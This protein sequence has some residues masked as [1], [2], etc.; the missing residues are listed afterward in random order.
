MTRHSAVLYACLFLTISLRDDLTVSATEE[1]LQ[2]LA[3]QS[4]TTTDDCFGGKA[5]LGSEGNKRCCAFTESNFNA[6]NGMYKGCNSCGDET[7]YDIY[8]IRTPGICETC[9]SGYTYLDGQA[10]ST[11]SFE[12]GDY[13]FLGRCI[14][15]DK[16]D[17][18]T[19]YI[20]SM[21]TNEVHCTNKVAAGQSNSYSWKCLSG[22]SLGGFC[23]AEGVTSEGCASGM[24]DSGTGAC[25][26]KSSPGQ[27][28]TTTDDCFGGNAC[29]GSEGNKRCCT[30]TR[31]RWY[32]RTDRTTAR[33]NRPD[34]LE[35]S[36]KI[37]KILIA[38]DNDSR[39]SLFFSQPKFRV[40]PKAFKP[41]NPL[42]T[43][44]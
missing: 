44:F 4:C 38:R 2:S 21:G 27:S 16:C 10:H 32:R 43:S 9:E 31:S 14:A 42:R 29:L 23:C 1:N 6:N 12:P 26:T 7:A 20:Y 36:Y 11:I 18:S 33:C 30:T 41:L 35:F 3:G 8:D 17:F 22:V 28:C 15:D 40:Y 25:S 39:I 13:E 37:P 34:F 5:C 19:Q 24:C